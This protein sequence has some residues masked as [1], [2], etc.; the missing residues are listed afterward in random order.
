MTKLL[1]VDGSALLHRAYHAY[2]KLTSRG[3]TLVNAVYGFA[4]ILISVMEA[5]MPTHVV[6]AWD[7]PKPTFRHE[8]YVGYKAQRPKVDTELIEQIP[9]VHKLVEAMQIRE[10]DLVGYEAD[11]IIGSL[12]VQLGGEMEE[13]II[14]TG[15][16]DT[17]Q[18][19]SEKVHVLL[20]AKGNDPVKLYG[21]EEMEARYGV[22]PSQMVDYKALV[23]DAGD[24]IPGVAGI[25]PKTAATLIQRYGTLD[26]IYANLTEIGE[27]PREL[28]Q[29]GKDSAYMSQ[30]L[31]RIVTDMKL[32]VKLDD[33]VRPELKNDSTYVFLERLGFNSMIKRLFGE[34]KSEKKIDDRQ[35]GMF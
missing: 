3:G 16:Q 27:K 18:L 13:T 14:L 7:L 9:L 34:K 28:L 12:G 26:K 20:P 23:G 29:R 15:D 11:D 33:L 17:M 4:S 19:V 21:P 5:E 1:L 24:N 25:G 31:S 10:V 30:H 2:P 6:V 35:V 22:T 32:D 8:F